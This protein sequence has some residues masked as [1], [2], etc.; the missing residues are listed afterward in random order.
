MM[1]DWQPTHVFRKVI[2]RLRAA[3]VSQEK[4]TTMLVENPRRYFAESGVVRA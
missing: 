1:P 4:I 3:G 2:P